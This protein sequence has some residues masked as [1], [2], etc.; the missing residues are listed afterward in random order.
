LA[1]GPVQSVLA[2]DD[3]GGSSVATTIITGVDGS[4]TA[5]IA[6][7]RAAEITVALEGRLH[8]IS[9]YGKY[10]MERFSSGEEEFV[11][12]SE[13]QANRTAGRVA[14]DLRRDFPALDVTAAAAE[15]KP[16]KALVEAAER[17]AADVIVVGNKRVQ[18]LARVLGSI[19]RDVAAHAPCDVYVAH[20][21]Q[22]RRS[23]KSGRIGS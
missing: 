19:A 6:A 4:E 18:G 21:Q 5:A 2:A 14:S 17:L 22:G 11:V 23:G 15:G 20:T 13:D 12:T 3:R 16:D 9:A 7:R 10:E 8:V 1:T